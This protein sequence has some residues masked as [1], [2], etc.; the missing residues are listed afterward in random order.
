MS[1]IAFLVTPFHIMNERC[2]CASAIDELHVYL[3][4]LYGCYG[5]IFAKTRETA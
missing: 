2:V 1:F 3:V 5:K 4:F